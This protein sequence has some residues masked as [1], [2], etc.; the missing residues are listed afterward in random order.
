MAP[1]PRTNQRAGLVATTE[2]Y[3]LARS[4]LTDD[5]L[6]CQ[7]WDTWRTDVDDIKSAVSG[8]LTAFEHVY[9]MID[10]PRSRR[11]TVAIVGTARPLKIKPHFVESLLIDHPGVHA[12]ME[13]VGL[14]GPMLSGLILSD[15][16][17]LELLAPETDALSDDRPVL[18][19]RAALRHLTGRPPPTKVFTTLLKR[20]ADPR[21]W[22]KFTPSDKGLLS[23]RVLDT[24]EGWGELL[25]GTEDVLAEVGYEAPAFELEGPGDGPEIESI[26]FL[27]ALPA[28]HDWPYLDGLVLGQA[29]RFEREGHLAEAEAFLRAAVA[30]KEWSAVFRFNLARMVERQGDKVD[31]LELYGTVLAFD[32]DHAGATRAVTRLGGG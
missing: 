7:W 21:R 13:S 9:V 26:A 2:F 28:L 20:R 10:H 3:R 23:A 1:D 15:R 8:A 25:G 12:D 30:A 14:G 6:F 4:R 18:G 24:F 19:V 11:M 31:A 22:T 17:V 16:P 27:A 29:N 5:G 32:P